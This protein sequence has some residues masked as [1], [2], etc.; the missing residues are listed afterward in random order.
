M[1][2]AVSCV[3]PRLPE[4]FENV[5]SSF[6]STIGTFGTSLLGASLH[7]GTFLLTALK[8]TTG[9][10]TAGPCIPQC[11]FPSEQVAD[12]SGDH[13]LKAGTAQDH[14]PGVKNTCGASLPPSV[15]THTSS[16]SSSPQAHGSSVSCFQN[17]R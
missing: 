12:A 11:F 9:L 2:V 6:S 5:C 15:P 14:S 17:P 7:T 1:G 4:Y 3:S 8:K 10:C 16:P 13:C